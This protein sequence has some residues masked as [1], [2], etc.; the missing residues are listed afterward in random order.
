MGQVFGRKW[1]IALIYKA[2]AAIYL[3]VKP[4]AGMLLYKQQVYSIDFLIV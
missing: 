1:Q 2:L 3:I 4:F